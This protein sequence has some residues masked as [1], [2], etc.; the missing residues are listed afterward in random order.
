MAVFKDKW[1]GYNGERWRVSV[2]Y[3]DWTGIRRKHEKK[4]ICNKERGSCI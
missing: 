3:K 1:N 4:R 2:Y